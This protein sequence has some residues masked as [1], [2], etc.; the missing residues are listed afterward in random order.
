MAVPF[1]S[2]VFAGGSFAASGSNGHD[3]AGLLIYSASRASSGLLPSADLAAIGRDVFVYVS[4][5]RGSRGTATPGS[6]LFGGDTHV[7]GTAS[8]ETGFIQGDLT[9]SGTLYASEFKTTIVSASIIFRSGSTRFGDSA[10]DTHTFTGGITGSS[11][12]LLSGDLAVN[13]GDITSTAVSPTL[14]GTSNPHND[15]RLLLDLYMHGRLKLDELITRTYTLDE[16]NQ[17]YTDML[18]G[19]NLRGLILYD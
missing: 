4:G 19:R 16:V 8:A 2:T 9:V 17:G 10:D 18:E 5:S 6:V 3:T 12:M 1:K 13:G 14:F 7:S 11:N 15:I